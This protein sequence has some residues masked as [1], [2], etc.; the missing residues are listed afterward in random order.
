MDRFRI[1]EILERHGFLLEMEGANPFQV[2]AYSNAARALRQMEDF[3][4]RLAAGS[5]GDLPGFGKVLVQ[6][7]GELS[8]GTL[9][10]AIAELE[11]KYPPEFFG[12]TKVPGLGPRKLAVVREA[13]GVGSPGELE[14]ACREN[15]LAAIPGFGAK[16]QAKILAALEFLRRSGGQVLLPEAEAHGERLLSILRAIPGVGRVE[17]AG[18]LRRRAPT[19]DRLVFVVEAGGEALE[20]CQ[21]ALSKEVAEGGALA[22]SLEP[23]RFGR[24]GSHLVRATGSEPFVRALENRAASLG[25][26]LE[27]IPGEEEELFAA[28]G[29]PPIPPELREDPVWIAR[30]GAGTLPRLVET[31]DLG[32]LFH[33]HTTASD[34]ALTLRETLRGAA[35]LGFRLVGISDHSRSAVYA[36]GL[37][38]ERV[39]AQRREI[40]ELRGEFPALTILQG[41]ESDILGEGSL[42]FDEETLSSFDFVVASVHS[43]LGM[44]RDEMTARLVAAVSNRYTTIL[45]H[46]SGRLLLA[47]PPAELDLDA[48]LD[49]AAAHGTAVEINASPHRLDLDWEG[50]P[51]AI[52]RGIA[53]AIDPDA[54]S[55]GDLANCRYGIDVARRGGATRENVWN[56][57]SPEEI[58]ARSK[59]GR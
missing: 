16:S 57:G 41:T 55:A 10:G 34:G 7:V 26:R 25:L 48:V 33:L 43:R 32:G 19:I 20:S 17:G 59:K 31:R 8:G 5:L 54:H 30:A 13:L 14:Y 21:A 42:D 58:V 28:L 18:P 22:V 29:L 6:K 51:K 44:S 15:R 24:F 39:R 46:P 49:A 2:R 50:V 36:G 27:E 3:E 40:D 12:L 52:A 9:P 56:A 1:A 4:E 47:R 11:A 53:L 35:A 23:A 37:D 45:G 38:P